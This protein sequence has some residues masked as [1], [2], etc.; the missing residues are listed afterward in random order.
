MLCPYSW[1]TNQAPCKALFAQHRKVLAEQ[2]RR[3]P[4]KLLIL[5]KCTLFLLKTG[6]A[7]NMLQPACRCSKKC[8]Q[9]SSRAGKDEGLL[10]ICPFSR[11]RKAALVLVPFLFLAVPLFLVVPT[12]FSA[13]ASTACG[14]F[15]YSMLLAAKDEYMALLVA[16]L[17]ASA[18]L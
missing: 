1:L 17:W 18:S 10:A 6:R 12:C 11:T 4:S 13:Y 14:Y 8:L 15:I 9:H 3:A 5:S 7:M 2:R 16:K